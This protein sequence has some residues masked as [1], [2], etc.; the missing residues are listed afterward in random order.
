MTV[1][2]LIEKLKKE[3]QNKNVVVELSDYCYT[4]DFKIKTT[5]FLPFAQNRGDIGDKTAGSFSV[6]LIQAE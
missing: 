1:K 5:H 6:L 4:L 3:D 2:Q